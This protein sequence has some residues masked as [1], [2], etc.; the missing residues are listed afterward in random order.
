MFFKK[1][2]PI[3]IRMLRN[4]GDSTREHKKTAELPGPLLRYVHTIM[5]GKP[6]PL[7]AAVCRQNRFRA[8][9][10]GP[11]THQR[12]QPLAAV[13]NHERFLE[14]APCSDFFICR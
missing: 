5:S 14:I 11:F 10:I 2:N 7:T 8:F 3:C 12:R 1:T 6:L 4:K 13:G 9:P